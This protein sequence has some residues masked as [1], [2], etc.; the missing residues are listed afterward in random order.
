MKLTQQ[1]HRVNLP[2][3]SIGLLLVTAIFSCQKEL[4]FDEI[5]AKDHN[6]V[7]KFI[8]VVQYDSVRL[9]LGKEY[10]NIF[11]E[12]YTPTAFKFYIHNFEMSNT[13][14]GYSFK[15]AN[16][17][18][19]L[20]DFADSVSTE[21][22]I[23]VRPYVYNRIS[24]TIGVDSAQN[25]SGAQTG[26]LDPALGMFWDRTTGYI[27]AKLEGTSS[28]SSQG[29]KFEYHIGG[30]TSAESVI[31]KPYLLF[32]FA[33]NLELQ[34]GQTSQMF[35]TCDANDWF[36]NPHDIKIAENPV[37]KTPGDLAKQ[38]AENYSK[39]FTVDSVANE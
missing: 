4:K 8:P 18:Y 25:V 10:Q 34:P 12:R 31:K 32:P 11:K 19:Y 14:S 26:A 33:Q 38:I 20:V 29:G 35:I 3:L 28:R 27:M 9:E 5:P 21:I 24:F 30:F 22:K 37:V 6:L 13:D 2:K 23:A 15:L 1:L 7:L 36:Y 16:D 39:M 17:K